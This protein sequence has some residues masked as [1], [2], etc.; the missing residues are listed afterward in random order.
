[1]NLLRSWQRIALALAM[2]VPIAAFAQSKA[3][4]PSD[5]AAAVPA[6]SYRSVFS[7]YVAYQDATP[8][9]WRKSN[10][11]MLQTRGDSPAHDMGAMPEGMPTTD[12]AMPANGMRPKAKE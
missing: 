12:H 3:A 11:D 8:V 1:M 7:D 4:D 5:P 2:V 6:T 10:D 9:P